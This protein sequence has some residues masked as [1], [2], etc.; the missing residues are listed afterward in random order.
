MQLLIHQNRSQ[1]ELGHLAAGRL[2]PIIPSVLLICAALLSY[3]A[4]AAAQPV[5]LTVQRVWTQDAGGNVKTIFA[6][7]EPIQF[8]AQ[9]SN[10]YGEPL[11][12]SEVT[13]TTPFYTDDKPAVIPTGTS[14]RTWNAT[15]PSEQNVY[16]YTITVKALDTVSRTW[17]MRNANF[18]LNT[19]RHSAHPPLPPAPGW[20]ANSGADKGQTII[21]RNCSPG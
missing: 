3:P 17:V 21:Y 9:L 4:I 10:P 1:G 2:R 18:G 13:L 5:A 6:P 12:S 20:Y 7:G 16:T 11:P 8:V 19:P 14:I 15:L